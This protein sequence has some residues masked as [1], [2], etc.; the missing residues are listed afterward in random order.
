MEIFTKHLFF[1]PPAP[2]HHPIDFTYSAIE[3][4]F[5]IVAET[6][7]SFQGETFYSTTSPGNEECVQ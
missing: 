7:L 4:N 3:E 5:L 1:F 2:L 6:S